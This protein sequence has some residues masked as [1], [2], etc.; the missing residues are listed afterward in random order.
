MI[1]EF[2]QRKKPCIRVN[3]RELNRELCIGLP[4]LYT[5]LQWSVLLL[6]L[7]T[8]NNHMFVLRSTYVTHII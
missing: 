5:K 6:L 2:D 1:L 4:T 7:S 8:L 3:T